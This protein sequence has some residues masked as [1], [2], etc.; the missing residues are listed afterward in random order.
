MFNEFL[1]KFEN[2]SRENNK[3]LNTVYGDNALKI[4]LILSALNTSTRATK[5]IKMRRN[6]DTLQPQ[7]TKKTS[8][9]YEI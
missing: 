1:V 3:M 8:I 9:I 7:L 4:N 2:N 5:T 6:Q